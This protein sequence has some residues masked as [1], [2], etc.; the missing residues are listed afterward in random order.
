[1]LLSKRVAYLDMSQAEVRIREGTYINLGA[2][3]V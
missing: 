2:I 3:N 1:M